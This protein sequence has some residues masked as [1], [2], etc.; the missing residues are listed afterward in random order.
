MNLLFHKIST[1]IFS[2]AVMLLGFH[3][4]VA[5]QDDVMTTQKN[6]T[7]YISQSLSD[8]KIFG[9][10]LNIAGS[11]YSLSGTGIS[12]S[13]TSITLSSL[14]ITQTSQKILDADLSDT[15]YVTIEPGNRTKQEIASCTTVVQNS[16]GTA[17]L[18]GCSRGLS[19]ISPYTASTT[20]QFVHS[21]GSQVIFS[22]PPQLF[23]QYPAKDNTE[24]ITGK[25]TFDDSDTY[26]AR[27]DADTDTAVATAFVTLGQLSRQAVSGASNGS[28]TVK[29]IFEAATAIEQA[30]STPTGSTGA[31]LVNQALYAT[32]TATRGCNGTSVI[33]AL[34]VIVA[35]N[36]GFIDPN[37]IS[38]T[39]T[40][41]YNFGAKQNFNAHAS[42]TGLSSGFAYFGATATSSFSSTGVLT[43]ATT[44]LGLVR[45]NSS[46]ITYSSGDSARFLGQT[47]AV[48][49][50]D[51]LTPSTTTPINIPAGTLGVNGVIH[52]QF[53]PNG[54]DTAGSANSDGFLRFAL[55]GL[56]YCDLSMPDIANTGSGVG[57]FYLYANGNASVYMR[58][59]MI[60]GITNGTNFG[61]TPVCETTVATSTVTDS[62]QLTVTAR[63]TDQDA[64]DTESISSGTIYT[65][66]LG[67]QN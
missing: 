38:T 64:G 3:G 50:S 65:V 19:P 39:S 63:L 32:S 55:G 12:S 61:Q 49:V 31:I 58:G 28:E 56:S 15:F 46:G 6:I 10:T 2:A 14:T 66:F 7:T 47:T 45:T 34:C 35:Q 8:G 62:L 41:V 11:T 13:A 21:G 67:R 37:R 51:T 17:T 24:T 16:N 44:T 48:S 33:G 36:N 60:T 5:T 20:L 4:G 23:A 53:R 22:D 40:A 29:G 1:I 54:S 52:V 25:W 42:T 27:I 59:T 9:S 30:S 18:S 57:D 26:R 43:L